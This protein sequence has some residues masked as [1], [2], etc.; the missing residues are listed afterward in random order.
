MTTGILAEN[1]AFFPIRGGTLNNLPTFHALF[2]ISKIN[3]KV[4]LSLMIKHTYFTLHA[5][6]YL[7]FQ[8]FNICAIRHLYI[9]VHLTMITLILLIT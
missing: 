7:Y 2:E 5:M 1:C 6:C 3:G 4:Q 9:H 8:T